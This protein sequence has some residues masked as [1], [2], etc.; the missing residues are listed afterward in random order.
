M[1]R[2]LSLSLVLLAMASC[3]SAKDKALDFKTKGEAKEL[4]LLDG[5]VVRYTAYTEIR[6]ATNAETPSEQYFNFFVPEGATQQSP[7]LFRAG[8]SPDLCHPRTRGLTG[9][10]LKEGICLCLMSERPIQDM[11]AVVRYLRYNDKRMMGSAERIVVDADLESSYM[12]ALVGLTA[13]HPDYETAVGKM[14]AAKARDNVFAVVCYNPNGFGK[15]CDEQQ[16]KSAIIAAAQRF[17]DE[18]GELPDSLG[19]AFHTYYPPTPAARPGGPRYIRAKGQLTDRIADV[20]LDA[21]RNYVS[22]KEQSLKAMEIVASRP[23]DYLSYIADKRASVA[24]HWY[25]RHGLFCTQPPYASSINLAQR[26]ADAGKDVSFA[27]A[28]NRGKQADYNLDD[29]FR[30]LKSIR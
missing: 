15:E 25:I 19:F 14:G 28:W 27:L 29:L 3:V 21:F 11:K 10:A 18:G 26:L 23:V 8:L 17:V 24:P 5:S 6:Y 20:D 22:S 9:R 7:I 13:N 30:W 2:I 1:K 16:Q 4:T 12:S